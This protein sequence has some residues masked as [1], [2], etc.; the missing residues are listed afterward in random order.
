M[1]IQFIAGACKGKKKFPQGIR[2]V[3]M[4][5]ECKK[6]CSKQS[7]YKIEKRVSNVATAE[8]NKVTQF[9]GT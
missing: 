1:L 6:R 2:T 9:I 8:K 3:K 5:I 4:F 7:F